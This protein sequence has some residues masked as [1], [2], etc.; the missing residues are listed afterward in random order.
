M[1]SKLQLY[2]HAH[3]H[4]CNVHFDNNVT[5]CSVFFSLSFSFLFRTFHKISPDISFYLIFWND[6]CHLRISTFVCLCLRLWLRVCVFL[7]LFSN[8]E[9]I[10][11]AKNDAHFIRL[12]SACIYQRIE[13]NTEH[14]MDCGMVHH[15]H[16][17]ALLRRRFEGC[18]GKHH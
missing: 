7:L 4:I 3:T 1:L 11:F 10:T 18:G 15:H 12:D 17:R 16:H 6:R 14:S 2:A 8:V 13:E 5:I 9:N